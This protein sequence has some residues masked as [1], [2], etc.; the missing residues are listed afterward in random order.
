VSTFST[1]YGK[2]ALDPG[3]VAV[4][5]TRQSWTWVGDDDPEG[6]PLVSDHADGSMTIDFAGFGYRNLSYYVETDLAI[7][8]TA[9]VV[10]GTVTVDCSDGGNQR[11]VSVYRSS[12]LTHGHG[13]CFYRPVIGFPSIAVQLS[14]ITAAGGYDK[15]SEHMGGQ[16]R[17]DNPLENK[18]PI[19]LDGYAPTVVYNPLLLVPI[20]GSAATLLHGSATTEFCSCGP[21]DDKTD[22]PTC[23]A[24][25]KSRLLLAH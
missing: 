7:A 2:V 22:E 25:T 8:M 17:Q 15:V 20:S 13:E 16:S 11:N 14:D 6:S 23:N 19:R 4:L 21:W 24:R 18:A 9:G 3:A 5:R 10:D 12:L 1:I